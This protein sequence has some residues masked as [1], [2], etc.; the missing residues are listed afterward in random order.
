MSVENLCLYGFIW[1]SI[2]LLIEL[3][4]AEL[5]ANWINETYVY[6]Y[7][8]SNFPLPPINEAWVMVLISSYAC[9][10]SGDILLNLTEE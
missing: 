8:R 9:C 4:K 10:F 1:Q 3:S 5:F 7:F 2:N 6:I